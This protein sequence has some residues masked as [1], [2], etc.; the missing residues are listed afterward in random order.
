[1]DQIKSRLTT[2]NSNYQV[3]CDFHNIRN[4]KSGKYIDK[5]QELSKNLEVR[6]TPC[7]TY[8]KKTDI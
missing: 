3:H 2:C 5:W 8:K 4:L 1:M 6:Q 7:D